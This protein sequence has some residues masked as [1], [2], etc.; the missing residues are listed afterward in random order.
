MGLFSRWI[1]RI[2]AAGHPD[3]A[4]FIV[5]N[6][7]ELGELHLDTGKRYEKTEKIGRIG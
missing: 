5:T 3:T 7:D 6:A 1:E 2:K 4:A